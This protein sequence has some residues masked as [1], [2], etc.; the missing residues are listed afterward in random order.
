MGPRGTRP[1]R[2]RRWSRGH[3]AAERPAGHQAL[4]RSRTGGG[5][6]AAAPPPCD[7]ETCGFA[8]RWMRSRGHLEIALMADG[9]CCRQ[10]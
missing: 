9:R 4:R 10:R 3:R 8:F 1:W 7:A 5:A 2:E 6:K